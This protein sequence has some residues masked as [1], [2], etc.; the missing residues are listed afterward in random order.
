MHSYEL[1]GGEFQNILVSHGC[2][3]GHCEQAFELRFEHAL[4]WTMPYLQGGRSYRR[5]DVC[6]WSVVAD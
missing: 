1:V 6:I 2:A 4:I 3:A 5:V